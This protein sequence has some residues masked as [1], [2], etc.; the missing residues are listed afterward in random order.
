MISVAV[1]FPHCL[2]KDQPPPDLP[3]DAIIT[4]DDM[5]AIEAA[6]LRAYRAGGGGYR[7]MPAQ[8]FEAVRR[9]LAPEFRVYEPLRLSIDANAEMLARL[10]RQ[11]LQVLRGFD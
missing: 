1:A 3:R 6:I 8:D 11:Q 9:A 2:F 5:A 7:E 4:M 10:T